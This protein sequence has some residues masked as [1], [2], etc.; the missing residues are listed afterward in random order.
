M[1]TQ[2]FVV[3]VSLLLIFVASAAAWAQG[4]QPYPN[5]F[6]DREVHLKTPMAPP[7]INT[8]FQDPDFGALM[9]RATDDNTNPKVLHSY[10]RNPESEKNAWSADSR[11]FF[12]V[13]QQNKPLAFGFDPST[14]FISALPG[15]GAGGGFTIPLHAGPT[16]SFVDPDLMYGT[17]AHASLT[18]ASFRFSTGAVTPLIDT[19]TSATQP[20]MESATNV[21]SSGISVSPG[22]NRPWITAGGRH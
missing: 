1:T 19:T 21:S 20:P 15:A 4:V 5:A 2:R 10:F 18:M 9:V 12:L 17:M 11:K 7:S 6:T 3:P 14:M 13:S 8:V 22:G 16:F